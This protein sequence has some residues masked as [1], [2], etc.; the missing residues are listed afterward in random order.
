MT[1]KALIAYYTWS[2]NTR[3]I[4]DR[5]SKLIEADIYEIVLS[6]PYSSNYNTCLQESRRDLGQNRLLDIKNPLPDISRYE[7]LL[8][9]YPVWFG[10]YPMP[11]ASFLNQCNP[12]DKKILPFSTHGGG[13]DPKGLN[14]LRK[15]CPDNTFGD[16][17]SVQG[18]GGS[19]LDT[20]LRQWV[21]NNNIF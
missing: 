13:G 4:A 1:K 18:R 3:Y 17:F 21:K 15:L 7:T 12:V 8:I 6:K 2:G 10:T 9:G 5:I 16:L 14:D 11:M 20:Y 19:N